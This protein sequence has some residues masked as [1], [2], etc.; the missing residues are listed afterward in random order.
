MNFSP[1]SRSQTRKSNV[2]LLLRRSLH[3][4]GAL[5]LASHLDGM[6]CRRNCQK[7]RKSNAALLLPL[8]VPVSPLLH[9]SYKKM[10]GAPLPCDM[11]HM[12][13][14]SA[15]NYQCFLSL[16]KNDQSASEIPQC[17]LS[18]TSIHSCKYQ[19]FLSLKK[20]GGG[21][22]PSTNPSELLERFPTM[23]RHGS[24]RHACIG[25][26]YQPDGN[27]TTSFRRNGE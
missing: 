23:G 17:F 18:L 4:F 8:F 7:T 11:G 1:H 13:N 15:A 10:G 19:C 27:P 22:T 12:K 2:A 6:T 5:T 26:N 9:Y 25:Y 20:K 3:N 16:T 14:S 24:S 21:G